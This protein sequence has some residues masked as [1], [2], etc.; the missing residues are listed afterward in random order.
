MKDIICAIFHNIIRTDDLP[1]TDIVS[2]KQVNYYE[3]K[4]CNKVFMAE[5]KRNW[6]RVDTERNTIKTK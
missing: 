4:K 1:F 6:F 5:S 3:C 2:G